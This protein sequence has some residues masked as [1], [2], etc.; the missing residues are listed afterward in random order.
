MQKIEK[1]RIRTTGYG[2]DLLSALASCS[3]TILVREKSIMFTQSF[4]TPQPT[5]KF[6]NFARWPGRRIAH[7][8]LVLLSTLVLSACSDND[9]DL[10]NSSQTVST[11]A[12]GMLVTTQE[13]NGITFHTLTAPETQFANS[14]HLIETENSLVVFDTQFLLPNAQDM[15][16]YADELGKTIDRVFITHEHPDHFL[17]SEVFSD[18]PIY[19]LQSVSELISA[20]GDAEVVE[21]QGD[22]GAENIASTYVVPQVVSPGT[23]LID[24]IT[25]ELEQVMDAE[26]AVQLV[27]RLPEHGVIITGDIVYSG[28]HLILAGQPASWTTAL[29]N[30][31]ASASQYPIV[32]AGHG[33]PA[34]PGVYDVNIAWLTKAAELLATVDNGQDF[35]QG[36]VDAFPDLTMTAAIDFVLPLLFPAN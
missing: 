2:L 30:L 33:A 11:R 6:T 36:L 1:K 14:T 20:N 27:V 32:L 22:F 5:G 12:S 31:A 25:F 34:D 3:S 9:D 23:I 26:A 10:L 4:L 18:R 13:A 35:K 8:T 21:K 15:R 29:E 17:G 16:A 7:C 19:S 24:G 28:V